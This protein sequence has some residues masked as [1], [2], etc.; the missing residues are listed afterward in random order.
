MKKIFLYIITLVVVAIALVPLYTKK[1]VDMQIQNEK[2]I[3]KESGIELNIINQK[4]YISSYRE[5][6]LKI[7]NGKKFR[8]SIFSKITYNNPNYKNLINLMTKK[9]DK[10]IRSALDGMTFTGNLQ[11]SNLYLSPP[12]I[13]L[14]LIK[15]SNKAMLSL[16]KNKDLLK[17]ITSS[18]KEKLITF[19]ITLDSNQKITKIIMKDIDKNI[20]DKGNNINVKLINHK[21]SFDNKK[22]LN[23]IYTLEEQSL[24]AKDFFLITKGIEYKFDYINQFENSGNFHIDSLE[25]TQKKGMFKVG[26]IDIINSIKNSDK[27][28]NGHVKYNIKDV[29][30]DKRDKLELDNI[31]FELTFNNLD[32]NNTVEASS[33]YNDLVFS[34]PVKKETI[35]KLTNALEKILN[36]GFNIDIKTSI[37]GL[38]FKNMLFNNADFILALQ[39]NKNNFKLK[40]R[41]IIKA[42]SIQGKLTFDKQNIKDLMKLNSKFKKLVKLGK[43]IGDKIVFNYKFENG[44]L[45]INGEKI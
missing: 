28:L 20:D 32:K 26:S 37:N 33:A 7:I 24:K 36:K 14:S 3:L 12:T 35:D 21:L 6:E 31:D 9:S 22:S 8:N 34:R 27:T 25:I 42:F 29:Y 16:N 13:E 44:D 30:F 11:N 1:Q 39:V 5:F 43:R 38:G 17:F 23:G 45:F 4:G 19:Y 15:L 40:S 18:L 10:D 41:D 2:Q